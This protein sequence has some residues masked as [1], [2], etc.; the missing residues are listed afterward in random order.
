MALW[1]YQGRSQ[2]KKTLIFILASL[3]AISGC[4][5]KLTTGDENIKLTI[6][7]SSYSMSENI[8]ITITITGENVFFLGPCDSWFERKTAQGWVTVG[9]CPVSNFTDLPSPQKRGDQFSISLPTSDTNNPYTYNYALLAGTY[10]YAVVYRTSSSITCY[11]H[12]FEIVD[13]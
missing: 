11:S 8:Q 4:S 7:Q 3:I 13:H 10:R 1:A 12:E 2:M 6:S 9:K 5:G